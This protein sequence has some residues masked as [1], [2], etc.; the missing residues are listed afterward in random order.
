MS[1][2]HS[3]PFAR[4]LHLGWNSLR[5]DLRAGE[6]TVLLMAVTLAVAALTAV[7][8][9]ADRLQGGLQRDA[10]Q[11]LG[12]DAVVASDHG[13]DD[14]MRAQAQSLGL[15][16]AVTV[17]FPT[18]ARADDAQGGASRLVSLKAVE[19]AYPL[20][21][22]VQTSTQWRSDLG[23][24]ALMA[25]G[26]P[27]PD[28]PGRGEV[29]ADAALLAGLELQL[30]DTLHLGDAAFRLARVITLEPDRGA[31][32]MSFS[33]RV[34]MRMDEL[35]GT[36]LVQPASRLNWRL[37][38][39]GDDA[40]ALA[41][42][43]RDAQERIDAGAERGLRLMTLESGSPQMQRTIERAESF[44]RLVALL[45]ALLAAVGVALAARSFA[46]R[47]LDGAALLRVLGLSQRAIIGAY[48]LEFVLAGL[49]A[50]LAGV[51]IGYAVHHVF[52]AMLAG[53][54]QVSLPAASG[55]PVLLGLG[56]GLTLLL[57]FGL[58]PVLQLAQVP[59]LR[60]MRRDVG[61]LRPASRG[62]IAAGLAG[63]A[64]LLF[65]VSGNARL[66]GIA[67]GGFALAVLLFAVLAALAIRA[68]RTLVREG[69]APSWLLLATRQIAARPW[70]AVI[71]VSS[72]AVGLLALVLLVLLRTDLLA[73]WQQ[74]APPDANNR[75][76]INIQPDQAEAFQQALRAGGV[77]EYQW[78]PMIR[79]RLTAINDR[80]VS[81]GD[82]ADEDAARQVE[83]EFNLSHADRL[84]EG[85]A[86][87]AGRWTP[88]EADGL[89]MEVE[90]AERLGIH[91]GD[92]LR[93]DI[94][95]IVHEAT[96]TSLRKL[97]W[98]SMNANF[99][100][101]YPVAAMPDLP[102]TYLAAYRA[103]DQPGFDNA[104]VRQFPNITNVDM[105]ATLAQVQRVL[106]Q[107]SQAVEFLFLFALA[108]GLIVLFAAV[109]ATRDERA[110]EYAVMRAMG[111]SSRLLARVQRAELLGVG[112]LAGALASAVAM[113]VGWALARFVFDF[114]WNAPWWVPLAGALAGAVL[115]W[116]AGWWGLR[117]VLRRPVSESLRGMAAQ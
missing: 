96:V 65:V 54:V 85:N 117:G 31:G 48:L 104:L 115:A 21:G 27:A 103:P 99:F 10:R 30:G 114:S 88:G 38:V 64:V 32:F 84:P 43:V 68:L 110:R 83:R 81:A 66:G 74:S 76:V 9:F 52:I 90:I 101:L 80:A 15:R 58:A 116:L 78:Y 106:G 79:G 60:V 97:D 1:D 19:P 59:P 112:T 13:I 28:G 100:V 2:P 55:W 109:T 113:A 42:F 98:G 53:L 82:Y 17:V 4:I 63:F 46:Q 105:T 107:V 29:W 33:P 111:A 44:L 93:F 57:A 34:M 6:L 39:A 92:R 72:L 24:A 41:R 23:N 14:A 20:R 51:L 71:Q 35:E 67:V 37:L 36:G 69:R 73:S 77:S 49:F 56:M 75:F 5:R 12:G 11:L 25:T 16:S 108:A 86:V 70:F 7:G 8:F 45:V 95:G 62:V 26:Q 87:V 91:L 89:S 102:V 47:H 40:P 61:A 50:S 22:S 3:S 94:G 18:M